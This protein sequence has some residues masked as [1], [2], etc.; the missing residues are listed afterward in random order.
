MVKRRRRR[1]IA[2]VSKVR[3]EITTN[4]GDKLYAD[5]QGMPKIYK[6]IRDRSK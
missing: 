2:T 4:F 1:K 6:K 3:V 5:L